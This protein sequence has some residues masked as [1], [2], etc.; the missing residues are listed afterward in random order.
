[1]PMPRGR[2]MGEEIE[3]EKALMSKVHFEIK[4]L[5]KFG[6]TIGSEKFPSSERSTTKSCLDGG[7]LLRYYEQGNRH[8]ESRMHEQCRHHGVSEGKV[9]MFVLKMDDRISL[10]YHLGVLHS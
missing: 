5:T 8:M 1:M 2:I 9:S 7:R 6:E 3:R 4:L 10:E